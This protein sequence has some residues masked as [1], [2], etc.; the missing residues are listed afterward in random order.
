VQLYDPN[1]QAY[2]DYPGIGMH[3]EVKDPD[4]K[5]VLSKLSANDGKFTF[6]SHTPGEH[7]IC[8]YS[9]SSTWFSGA[10]LVCRAG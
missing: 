6:V 2:A 7:V 1:T 9:N 8:L 10:Q 5:V 3:I 4:N